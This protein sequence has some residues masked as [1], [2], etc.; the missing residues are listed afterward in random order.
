[1]LYLFIDS[2]QIK[3]I[4][5]R[6]SLLGQ[7]E[8]SFFEK[9]HEV[10]LLNNNQV[11][12][13]DLLASAIKDGL[14]GLGSAAIKEKEVVLILSQE[15]FQFFRTEIPADVAPSAIVSFIKD[16]ARASASIDIDN[17]YYDF[18]IKDYDNKKQVAFFAFDQENLKK[19]KE[20][21]KLLDLKLLT[22]IPE[23]LAYFKLFEKTLKKDKKE[24]IFYVYYEKTLLKGYLYD[25]LGL[26]PE[27][28]W[29][30]ILKDKD[31]V[32]KILKEKVSQ[33]SAE[34]LKINRIILSGPES[35]KIRQD[36]F[37]KAVGAWTNPLKRIIP[38][39]Y[40][41]YLKLLL[42]QSQSQF[43]ILNFDVCFGA[44]IFIQENKEFSILK[45]KPL[46]ALTTPSWP[47]FNL[48][49]IFKQSWFIFLISFLASFIFFI[50]ISRSTD[51]F[52][53]FSF[54]GKVT[55]TPTPIPSP[56]AIPTPS[57][58][59][60]MIKL[61]I[62]NGSGIAGKAG[63]LKEILSKNN[64][65]EILTGNA[66]SFDY[67]TSI[68]QIKKDKENIIGYLK[69][70]LKDYLPSFKT[71]ELKSDEAADAVIIIGKDFK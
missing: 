25:S 57:I 70:D 66:E 36:T 55:P 8:L 10:N 15:N 16:K 7:Q 33:F 13:V 24:I 41:D 51:N 63:E 56:T 68:I 60:E 20:V 12:D 37:T 54:P 34:G 29:S 62:L 27:Q 28:E 43:P 30:L 46:R 35:E 21:M 18:L 23:S 67:E 38:H 22:I 44:F 4:C 47:K 64:Y 6:K 59:R 40:E 31:D 19:F 65:Q 39:F 58:K 32:V 49:G 48:S 17:T 61:K 71:E 9:K 1:M 50:L 45:R 11:V 14:R 52:I 53:N 42:P 26:L 2:K 3:L 69:E 5:L